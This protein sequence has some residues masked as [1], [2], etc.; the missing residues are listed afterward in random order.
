MK[1]NRTY[2][3]PTYLAQLLQRPSPAHLPRRSSSSSASRQR[4]GVARARE[5]RPPPASRWRPPFVLIRATET[6][7]TFPLTPPNPLVPL[8]SP[9]ELIPLLCSSSLSSPNAP[10]AADLHHRGHGPSLVPLSSP[11]APPRPPLPPHQAKPLRKLCI[12]STPSS[13]SSTAA[14]GR[15]RFAVTRAPPSSSM[16][17]PDAL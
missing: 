8:P 16:T 13:S 15:R 10:A 6:P 1:Q 2:L 7:S 9:T 5:P 3:A 12:A 17:P 4:R 11:G 14:D